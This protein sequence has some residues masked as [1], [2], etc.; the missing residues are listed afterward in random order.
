MQTQTAARK[1]Q[2]RVKDHHRPA[3][4]VEVVVVEMAVME[5]VVV[6]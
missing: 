4:M 1:E 2:E 3:P 6:V 5:V